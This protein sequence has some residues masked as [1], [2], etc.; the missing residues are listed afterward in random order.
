M[1]GVIV[2]YYV[3]GKTEKEIRES[4]KQQTKTVGPM[5]NGFKIFVVVFLKK[6]LQV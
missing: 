6:I 1:M 5:D 4:G 2:N 3:M